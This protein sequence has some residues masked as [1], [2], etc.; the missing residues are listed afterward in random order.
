MEFAIVGWTPE[1]RFL[2]SSSVVIRGDRGKLPSTWM[3]LSVKSIESW[4]YTRPVSDRN[5]GQL[6]L[7][8]TRNWKTYPGGTQVLNGR[9]SVAC[10]RWEFT[11]YKFCTL[12]K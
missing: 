3:S 4:G 2:A 11:R 5:E 7:R 6:S 10:S 9:D 8:G 1:T 12:I